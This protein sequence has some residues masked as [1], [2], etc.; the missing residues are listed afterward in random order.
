[1]RTS[2]GITEIKARLEVIENGT[3]TKYAG[4]KIETV[5]TKQ[6]EYSDQMAKNAA[7][8]APMSKQWGQL[9]S[10]HEHALI[11]TGQFLGELKE[12]ANRLKGI[13]KDDKAVQTAMSDVTVVYQRVQKMASDYT[14]QGTL[15]VQELGKYIQ[16]AGAV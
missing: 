15:L 13:P 14:T 5:R 9:K 2:S 16:A 1:M 4:S 11:Q 8:K 3:L 10:E 7:L 12:T 6:K